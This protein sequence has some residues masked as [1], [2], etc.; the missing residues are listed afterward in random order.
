MHFSVRFALIFFISSLGVTCFGAEAH[1]IKLNQP[2]K[3]EPWW[4][5]EMR[6]ANK[7]L[8]NKSAPTSKIFQK[9]ETNTR[10]ISQRNSKTANP[11]KFSNAAPYKKWGLKLKAGFS[12]PEVTYWDRNLE[13][14]KA[15]NYSLAGAYY[16][17]NG[18]S[19]NAEIQH[20]DGDGKGALSTN[21]SVGVAYKYSAMPISIGLNYEYA[22]KTTSF[23]RPFLSLGYSFA[24]YEVEVE[25][26]ATV[27]EDEEGLYYGGGFLLNFFNAN[28]GN[29]SHENYKHFFWVFE[30]RKMLI[31]AEKSGIN[32]GKVM[33]NFGFEVRF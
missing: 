28:K 13:S 1:G 27:E 3:K 29:S 4:K 14:H 26:T 33:F 18:L 12:K 20:L 31:D 25:N 9:N 21:E 11:L 32:F 16:F 17:Q 23:F 22:K 6:L 7:S 15:V 5:E 8:V 2:E 19:L 10:A 24:D 30:A